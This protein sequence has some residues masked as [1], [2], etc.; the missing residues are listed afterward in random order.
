MFEYELYLL[1]R[2]GPLYDAFESVWTDDGFIFKKPTPPDFSAIT[3]ANGDTVQAKTGLFKDQYLFS[4]TSSLGG[5][6]ETSSGMYSVLTGTK[7]GYKPFG[8]AGQGAANNYS[9]AF[10][11]TQMDRIMLVSI[12][13]RSASYNQASTT[14]TFSLE[15]GA[16]PF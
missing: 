2:R 10:D 5:Y 4:N 7:S 6:G 8:A 9:I 16:Y 13:P 12:T 15:V 3:N 1:Y 11:Q 14:N